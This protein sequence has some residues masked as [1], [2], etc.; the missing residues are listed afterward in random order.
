MW[1]LCV[2]YRCARCAQKSL[3]HSTYVRLDIASWYLNV[4]WLLTLQAVDM[5]LS[6]FSSHSSAQTALLAWKVGSCLLF[7]RGLLLPLAL[8]PSWALYYYLLGVSSVMVSGI[9]IKAILHLC[10][11][12]KKSSTLLQRNQTGSHRCTWSLVFQKSTILHLNFFFRN[13]HFFSCFSLHLKCKLRSKDRFP[14]GR[15]RCIV[16]HLKCPPQ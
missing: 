12:T 2:W 1:V 10:V 6:S 14:T 8:L 15:T 9:T 16:C 13:S 11:E 4:K 3:C 5:S 7:D